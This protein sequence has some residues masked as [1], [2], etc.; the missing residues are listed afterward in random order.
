[1]DVPPL[2]PRCGSWVI[3]RR[4][5]G[6]AVAETFDRANVKRLDGAVFEAIPALTYLQ[7]LNRS[8]S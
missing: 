7:S 5:T 6:K 3:L 4:D 2:P 1:M 8:P